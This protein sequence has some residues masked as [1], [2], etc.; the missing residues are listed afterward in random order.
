MNMIFRSAPL[1]VLL[2]LFCTCVNADLTAGYTPGATSQLLSS[3]GGAGNTLF[4]DST[5]LGGSDVTNTGLTT[6]NSVLL[7]GAG[8]WSTGQ[9]VQITG[10]AMA[11]VG[12]PTRTGT[13]TFD[14]RQGSGGTGAS[15]AAGLNSLGTRT[16]AYTAPASNTAQLVY[17][18]FDTPVTFVA[19]A[20]TATIGINFYSTDQI[21][22]KVQTGT[23]L[24]RYNYGNG[25]LVGNRQTF[26]VAGIVSVPEPSSMVL[27]SGFAATIGLRRRRRV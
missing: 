7:P 12:G 16:A 1:F 17:A 24:L 2:C 22:Y 15:G 4:S 8:F 6:F 11:I 18:N 25:N 14:I 13:F 26:S 10:V 3:N 27:L 20:N 19:D 23:G 9:T 5:A 21:R